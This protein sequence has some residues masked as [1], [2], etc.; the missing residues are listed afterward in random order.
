MGEAKPAHNQHRIEATAERQHQD[1]DREAVSYGI[2]DAHSARTDRHA[3][4]PA[5]AKRRTPTRSYGRS[6]AHDT[7]THRSN[8][9]E[10][11]R[12]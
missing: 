9:R 7:N 8:R 12:I 2:G 6:E 4:T 1:K 5:A 10:A 3:L 11:I